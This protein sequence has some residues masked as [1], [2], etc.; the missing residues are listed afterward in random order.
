MSSLL[1]LQRACRQAFLFGMDSGLSRKLSRGCLPLA[2]QIHVYQNNA[3]EIFRTALE[4]GYP[5]IKRLVGDDCMRGLSLEYMRRF[6]S[7]SGD[8]QNYSSAFPALLDQLY[9]Q[10]DFSFL[11]DVARLEWF[12]EQA[13]LEPEAE[14]F[15]LRNLSAYES[16]AG[17]VEQLSLSLLPSCRLLK[18]AFP[19]FEIWRANLENGNGDAN[20]DAGTQHVLISRSGKDVMVQQVTGATFHLA[21]LF[22]RPVKLARAITYFIEMY[23][24]IDSAAT[25]RS[26]LE[27]GVLTNQAKR[28]PSTDSA[29]AYY[30]I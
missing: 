24:A 18:S 9:E 6:S 25:L 16:D 13:L 12:S 1:E 3:R 14:P 5:V 30:G 7:K 8:L 4:S 27:L 21:C 2:T 23:P 26:L 20:L 29:P 11:G 17:A 22:G 19:V 10:S 15:G 28:A